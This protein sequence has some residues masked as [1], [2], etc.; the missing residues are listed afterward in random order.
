MPDPQSPSPESDDYRLRNSFDVRP[1]YIS[2]GL[3][4]SSF[5]NFNP[6]IPASFFD[7]ALD[8]GGVYR[9]CIWLFKGADYYRYNLRS[10]TFQDGPRPIRDGFA[11]LGTPRLP[12]LFFSGINS[13][14]YAG[15]AFPHFYYVFRDEIY[16]RINSDI[17]GGVVGNLPREVIYSADEGPRGVLGAFVPGA[18]TTPDGR[19]LTKSPMV[20]LHGDGP[21]LQGMLHFFKDG[22][23]LRHNLM[24]G[25]LAFGPVPIGDAWNLPE[26]FVS[27]IDLAFYDVGSGSRN[28]FFISGTEYAL[29]DPTLGQTLRSGAVI[30][31]FAEF[32]RFLTRPQLFLVENYTLQNYVGPV[33]DGALVDTMIV[34]VGGKSTSIVVIETMQSTQTTITQSLLEDHGQST[35]QDFNNKVDKNVATSQDSDQYKY[36]LQAL[37]HGDV[38]ATG[39]WGGEVNASLNVQGG[40]NSL[41]DSLA[42]NVFDSIN[43]QV[44]ESKSQRVVK[45]FNSQQEVQTSTH[46]VKTQEFEEQNTTSHT[47][48]IRIVEQVQLY[49]A[50]LVLQSVELAYVDGITNPRTVSL[51]DAR[52]L[53]SDVFVSAQSADSVINFIR[54]ELSNIIDFQDVPRSILQTGGEPGTLALNLG[55]VSVIPLQ[56]P[57]GPTQNLSV[58]G[59]VKLKKEFQTLT[60]AFA[61]RDS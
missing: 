6:D 59:I 11:S 61:G 18:W 42:T 55:T 51:R 27:R 20:A 24:T 8:T 25:G 50:A 33:Q 29:Y 3:P 15:G 31:E 9:D 44:T 36:Y 53:L 49:L 47:L 23:Y 13:A 21:A 52:A 58:A 40:T 41:R 43:S 17:H 48:N 10:R 26:P 57:D 7:A 46:I 12:N 22:S 35:V 19:F 39:I 14:V 1:V 2:L 56:K 34:P 32:A 16:V 45:S 60:M 54:G 5:K 37:A 4:N 30:D 38:S 28:I